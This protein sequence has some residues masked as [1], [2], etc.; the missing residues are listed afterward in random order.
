MPA[1]SFH[2]LTDAAGMVRRLTTLR[3]DGR[4]IGADYQVIEHKED[5]VLGLSLLVGPVDPERVRAV[6]LEALAAG[7]G[8]ERLGAEFWRRARTVT[9]GREEPRATPAGKVLPFQLSR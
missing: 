4:P 9:V 7:G 1:P 3:R 8:L 2:D 5:G 6:F